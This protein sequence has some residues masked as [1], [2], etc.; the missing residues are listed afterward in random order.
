MVDFGVGIL[1]AREIAQRP[2]ETGRI[3]QHMVAIR[4]WSMASSVFLMVCYV[5]LC[6]QPWSVK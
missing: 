3:T 2:D 1:G 5:M 6:P 4:F